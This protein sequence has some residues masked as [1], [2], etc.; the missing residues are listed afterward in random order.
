M[1]KIDKRDR[2][3]EK[4]FTYMVTKANKI[5]IYYENR[6]IMILNEKESI[7]L[8]KGLNNKSEFDVQL[9]LAKVTGNFKRGNER[10]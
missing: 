1:S 8:Q 4:P 10:R 9:K 2:L 7:R 6:Q 3:K 5:I